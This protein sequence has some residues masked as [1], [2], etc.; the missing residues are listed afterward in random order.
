[1]NKKHR[2]SLGILILG[3]VMAVA[4]CCITSEKKS[5]SASETT[6]LK[7]AVDKDSKLLNHDD[8]D[9]LLDKIYELEVTKNYKDIRKL[10]VQYTYEEALSDHCYISDILN[11]VETNQALY[12]SFTNKVKNKQSAFIRTIQI[13]V[14]GDFIIVD[15]LY[16]SDTNRFYLVKDDT[17]DRYLSLAESVISVMEY[18]KMGEWEYSNPEYQIHDRYWIIYNNHPDDVSEIDA[19]IE[20]YFIL[21]SLK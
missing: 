4:L 9:T 3:A 11:P 7:E 12:D 19:T 20:D 17:R 15:V 10:P 5:I 14:E 1:M 16:D 18:S 6:K 13:T 21:D 2:I 8:K